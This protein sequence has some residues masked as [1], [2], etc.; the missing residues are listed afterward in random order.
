VTKA[1]VRHILTNP[2]VDIAATAPLL[3]IICVRNLLQ[4][5]GNG[6]GRA[7]I[8]WLGWSIVLLLPVF[9]AVVAARFAVLSF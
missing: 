9:L 6:K 3:V 7:S 1:F 8:R 4:A 5:A 2:A